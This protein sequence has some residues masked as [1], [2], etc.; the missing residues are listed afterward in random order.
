MPDVASLSTTETD[1]TDVKGGM[2]GTNDHEGNTRSYGMHSQKGHQLND[3]PPDIQGQNHSSENH[4]E[5]HVA[6]DDDNPVRRGRS[7]LERWTSH[8]ERDYIN[9]SIHS[10]SSSSKVGELEVNNDDIS[11]HDELI[12]TEDNN[13]LDSDIK[14]MEVAQVS[15][16]T[17][18]ESDRHLDTVAKLK[19]R[20]ERFK[21]PMPGDKETA[22]PRKSENETSLVQSET[23][24]DAD[25]KHERPARKRRWSSS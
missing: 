24:A 7:K 8:K 1:P 5:E 22:M 21:L 4:E 3:E 23:V 14:D 6:S 25:I 2:N 18:K 20:S 17:G 11:Q 19:K 15:D 12:K 13:I 10:L 16:M 9:S